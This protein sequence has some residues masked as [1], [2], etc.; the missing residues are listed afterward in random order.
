MQPQPP[1]GIPMP[2][3]MLEMADVITRLLNSRLLNHNVRIHNSSLPSRFAR[4]ADDVPQEPPKRIARQADD[5]PQEP[6]K[7][8]ARQATISEMEKPQHL[9]QEAFYSSIT[10]MSRK[11]RGSA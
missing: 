9:R 1:P 10:S 7:R 6:P 4:Q 2:P 8:V 11:K 5:V 3:G